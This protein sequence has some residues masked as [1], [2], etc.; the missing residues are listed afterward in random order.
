MSKILEPEEYQELI[1]KINDTKSMM[2][3]H[4]AFIKQKPLIIKASLRKF[5]QECVNETNSR[6]YGGF[7][8]T[9][10]LSNEKAENYIFNCGRKQNFSPEYQI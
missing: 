2:K 4:E 7:C 9:C 3:K 6:N 8:D 5:K 10:V 1:L